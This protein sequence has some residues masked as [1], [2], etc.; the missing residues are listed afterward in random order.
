MSSSSS[1]VGSNAT[2]ISCS[3][4][5]LKFLRNYF[6]CS[7]PYSRENISLFSISSYL[8]F[9]VGC[10]YV[11]SPTTLMLSSAQLLGR[12][13]LIPPMTITLL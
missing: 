12:N 7:S 9:F 1:V 2:I 3:V 11:V 5:R 6:E 4:L 13:D 10:P 8:I